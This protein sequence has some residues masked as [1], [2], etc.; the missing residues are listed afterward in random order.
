[1]EENTRIIEVNGVKLEIDLRTAKR[2]D[3]FKVG[4]PVK[5]LIKEYDKFKPYLGVIVG[6]DEFKKRPTIIIAYIKSEYSTASVE[7]AYINKESKEIELCPINDWDIPYSKSSIIEK[8]DNEILE[9]EEKLREI[10][11]KKNVFI[12]QFG[13]LFDK[14]MEG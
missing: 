9:K 4:S 7:F 8:F 12:S 14:Q 1:M 5:L 2:V 3:K 6:F 10:E 11:Q 13:K